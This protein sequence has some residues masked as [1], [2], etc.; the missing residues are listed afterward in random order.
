MLCQNVITIYISKMSYTT[1]ISTD[2]NKQQRDSRKR[3]EIH[4]LG[5]CLKGEGLSHPNITGNGEEK[6]ACIW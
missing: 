4:G 5:T 1:E 2:H 6:N 3:Q